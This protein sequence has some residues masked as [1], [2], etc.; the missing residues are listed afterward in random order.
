MVGAAA[1]V[2]A[3]VEAMA[4]VAVEAIM[5]VAG[6]VAEEDGTTRRQALLNFLLLKKFHIGLIPNLAG[7][8][9]LT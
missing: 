4:G 7:S 8:I 1:M 6:V 9:V 5:V 2:G 3:A